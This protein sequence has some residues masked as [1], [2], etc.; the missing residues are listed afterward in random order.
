[1]YNDVTTCESGVFAGSIIRQDDLASYTAQWEAPLISELSQA[2]V[3]LATLG[4]P[5]GGPVVHMIMQLIDS[6]CR[7]HR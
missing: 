3:R 7:C 6:A 4:A 2:G 5:S 1:M